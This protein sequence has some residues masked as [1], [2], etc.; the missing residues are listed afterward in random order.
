MS[1]F[2]FCNKRILEEETYFEVYQF[3]PPP[4]SLPILTSDNLEK[5]GKLILFNRLIMIFVI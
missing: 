3:C 4:P 1:V 5:L 2:V